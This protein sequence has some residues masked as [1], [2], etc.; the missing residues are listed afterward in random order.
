[1]AVVMVGTLVF[2][3]HVGSELSGRHSLSCLASELAFAHV[4]M[5]ARTRLCQARAP[6][7]AIVVAIVTIVIV[8]VAIITNTRRNH[9]QQQHCH[10]KHNLT[11]ESHRQLNHGSSSDID[12]DRVSISSSCPNIQRLCIVITVV[13]VIVIAILRLISMSRA[14]V[15]THA[16]IVI[17]HRH[18]SS[19]CPVPISR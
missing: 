11:N 5:G 16:V 10:Q 3:N 12:Y 9:Y 14:Q 13:A 17:S 18:R 15:V 8:M 7:S 4:C 1:M 6:S 2:Y 19:C